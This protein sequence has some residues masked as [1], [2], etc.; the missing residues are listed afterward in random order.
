VC[1]AAGLEVPPPPLTLPLTA[2][3]LRGA[4]VGPMLHYIFKH[5]CTYC[6]C[7]DVELEE[8]VAACGS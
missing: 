8:R 3:M 1:D 5:Y 7:T 6:C 2:C 4:V